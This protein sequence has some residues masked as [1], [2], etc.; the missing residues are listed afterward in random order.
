M[1]NVT[2]GSDYHYD[3][4]QT[5][6]STRRYQNLVA[7]PKQL[8]LL[9]AQALALPSIICF[10]ANFGIPCLLSSIPLYW[11]PFAFVLARCWLTT[12]FTDDR[13]CMLSL[14]TESCF[15]PSLQILGVDNNE[16]YEILEEE[17]PED[18]SMPSSSSLSS[19]ASY[20]TS[21]TMVSS[22]NDESQQLSS[23][24]LLRSIIYIRRA[25][26]VS[27][28]IIAIGSIIARYWKYWKSIFEQIEQ[29]WVPQAK[30][31]ILWLLP[32]T[33]LLSRFM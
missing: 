29:F 4:C 2:C 13:L 32:S 17:D 25:K 11:I 12:V 26:E 1:G 23:L 15:L 18:F 27:S 6:A 31:T 33:L 19:S 24:A 14:L 3:F 10:D 30:C 28:S 22:M 8:Q 9:D 7:S 21:P 5:V 20:L 16:G